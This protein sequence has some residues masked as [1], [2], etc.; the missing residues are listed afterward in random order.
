MKKTLIHTEMLNRF[1]LPASILVTLFLVSA[2]VIAGG[3]RGEG[4]RGRGQT[5][6]G[7]EP[8]PPHDPHDL[9]GIWVRRG[10]VLSLSNDAP[11]FTPEGKKRFDANKPSYGPRAIPPALGNDPMGN[12][13]PLGIPRL[14]LLENNPGD[15]EFI[16]IP[17]RVIQLFDRHHVHRIIWT[18]GRELLKDSDPRMLGYSVGHWEG[19][20]FVVQSNTFDDRT[21]L[22]HF[23]YPHSDEMRLEERYHRLDRDNMQLVMTLTDPNIYTKPWVS[24]TKNFRLSRLNEFAEELF[25]IPSQEQEFNRRVRD[26]AAGV[27]HK[28]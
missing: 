22:D 2:A 19:D 1:I 9:S 4:Q 21:W 12:C 24:E 17:G 15:L 3:Q 8:S 5:A 14:L 10:G 11:P 25:C 26:P 27:F 16:Q 28:D 20:V 18:D 7:N 13:D 23:G 6:A